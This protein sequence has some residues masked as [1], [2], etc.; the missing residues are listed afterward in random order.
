MN[1]KSFP[2]FTSLQLKALSFALALFSSIAIG[3]DSTLTG[4]DPFLTPPPGSDSTQTN[5]IPALEEAVKLS[6][7]GA[8]SNLNPK[9]GDSLDYILQVEWRDTQVPVVVLAPDTLAFEGFKILGQATVHSKLASNQDI[10]NHTEFI[11]RLRAKV[12]GTGR[13]GSLKVRY[14]TGLSQAEEAIFV[15]TAIIDILPAPVR[16]TD[17][18]WFKLVGGLLLLGAAVA[19][20]WITFRLM[21]KARKP[22]APLKID[23]QPEL[24]ELKNRLR[25]GSSSPDASKEII[26]NMEAISIRFLQQEIR[27]TGSAKNA[28]STGIGIDRYEPLLEK[29]LAGNESSDASLAMDWN[30]LTEL[31]RHARFAGGYKEPHELQDAF[32]TFKK[33]LK[34]TGEDDHE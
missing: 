5:A 13:A 24:K 31:F 15:P 26:L 14:M 9:A 7:Q 6:V 17:M 21:L 16:L 28:A 10:R 25:V 27:L 20:S 30:K 1:L 3:S 11:Y 32:R 8:F 2:L 4:R 22:S 34:L 18:L 33:C 29:Y 19:I 23:F 12:Q